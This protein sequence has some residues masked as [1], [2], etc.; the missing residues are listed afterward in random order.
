MRKP[1]FRH[2]RP[3]KFSDQPAHPDSHGCIYF[4]SDNGDSDQ[5]DLNLCWMYIS[6]GTLSQVE[7]H[8]Y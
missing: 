2:A 1:I 8:A 3:A 4:H 7:A 5:S 6:E